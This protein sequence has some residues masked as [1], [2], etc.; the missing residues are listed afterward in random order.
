M[1]IFIGKGTRVVVQGITGSQGKFHTRLMQ[2]FGTNVVAG[3][4][5]GKG[6][7]TCESVPVFDTVQEAVDKI[8]ANA[9]IVFVPPAF[10]ADAIFEATDAQL[11]IC[12]CITENI[13]VLD[14]I[15]VKAYLK[16]KKTRLIGPNCP[17]VVTPGQC[18]MGIMP[19]DIH[20]P[21]HIG[22]VSRSGSLT[23]ETI[24]QLTAADLGQ[25]TSV[26]I[27]G[28][29][30]S[31]TSFLDTV[32]AFNAD[33]DTYAVVMIGEIGGSGEQEA[34]AWI[35]EN[36]DMPVVAFIG[37]LSSPPGKRMG[38]AGAVVNG[39]S[40][41]AEEKV[42]TLREHGIPVAEIS[43]F[44]GETLIKSLKAKGNLQRC[45]ACLPRG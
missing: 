1:S 24:K 4:A 23:Y 16:G 35:K 13:P 41:S 3:T 43:D 22:V 21:G 25:S 17:G 15:Q 7:E 27:G 6:G 40:D 33:P 18:K 20:K 42:R 31:G 34:A 8:G 14:M 39:K 36:T 5:P 44:I 29:P 10:A 19:Q 12:I 37:G 38:H 30:V 11:S 2:E 45:M 28:D 32:K 26:G 9:S